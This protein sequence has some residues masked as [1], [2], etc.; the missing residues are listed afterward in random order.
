MN[1]SNVFTAFRA[2]QD[3]LNL[4]AVYVLGTNCA[5]NSPTPEA[6][7]NFISKGL[8]VD[9]SNVQGYEFM[10]VSQKIDPRMKYY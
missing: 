2:I 5:D 6:A 9:P 3:E 1:N 10:Q 4:K 7:Q 8:Q